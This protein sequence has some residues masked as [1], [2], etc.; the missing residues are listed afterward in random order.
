MF[1]LI[2]VLSSLT[3]EVL[4]WHIPHH[5]V[6]VIIRFNLDAALRG[7]FASRQAGLKIQREAG[8]INPNEWREH[9]NMNPRTDPG[10]EEYW[11]QGPSGQGAEP[12]PVTEPEPTG[13]GNRLATAGRT[14]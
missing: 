9:E 6:P 7:D 5:D 10:G 12:A 2:L 11:D 8:V 3:L 4:S 13:N 14:V 1:C